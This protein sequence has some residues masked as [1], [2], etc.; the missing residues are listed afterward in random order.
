MITLAVV[1]GLSNV[2]E[3]FETGGVFLLG[4][5]LTF[6]L[7]TLL[8]TQR[9]RMRWALIPAAIL[10]GM[11]ILITAAATAF[12]GVIWAAIPIVIGIYLLFRVFVPRREA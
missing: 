5:G 1:A 8:P 10:V 9:G 6:G 3:G 2:A 4:L 7:L 11:G 12:I